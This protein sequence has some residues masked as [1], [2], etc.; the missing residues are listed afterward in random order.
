MSQCTGCSALLSTGMLEKCIATVNW[1]HPEGR[2]VVFN[3][4]TLLLLRV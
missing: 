1:Q 3:R 4:N 2:E